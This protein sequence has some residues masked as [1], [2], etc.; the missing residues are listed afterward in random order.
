MEFC[1]QK[2]QN[3]QSL[4]EII[5]GNLPFNTSFCQITKAMH[6]KDFGELYCLTLILSNCSSWSTPLTD[7]FACGLMQDGAKVNQIS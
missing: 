6:T 2:H 5:I 3:I 1:D 7:V 4:V